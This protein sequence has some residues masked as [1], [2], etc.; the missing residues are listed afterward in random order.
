MNSTGGTIANATAKWATVQ[1]W[2]AEQIA[3]L[4]AQLDAVPEGTGTLLDHTI[5]LWVS[6]LGLAPSGNAGHRRHNV[7]AVI[8][9]GGAGYFNT[10]RLLDMGGRPFADLLLT[11][12][13][14]MGYEGISQFG[15]DSSGPI[16]ELIA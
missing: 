1:T 11:V 3:Y 8:A 10:G 6:E 12:G 16:H 7:P 15:A 2:H 5:V 4:L 13:H 14:A 9:G